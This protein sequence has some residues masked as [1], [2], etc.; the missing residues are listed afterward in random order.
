MTASAAK[1][2]SVERGADCVTVVLPRTLKRTPLVFRK[3]D[4]WFGRSVRAAVAWVRNNYYYW[5]CL[6]VKLNGALISSKSMHRLQKG[7]KLTF[8]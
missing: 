2:K 3:R 6:P 1:G 5:G 4:E 7:D 8:S